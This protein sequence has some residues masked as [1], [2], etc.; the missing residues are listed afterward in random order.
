MFV[1]FFLQFKHVPI[2][3]HFEYRYVHKFLW[4][5]VSRAVQMRMLTNNKGP[6]HRMTPNRWISMFRFTMEVYIVWKKK[7]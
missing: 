5:D 1:C 4:I 7:A 3:L 6:M 2:A